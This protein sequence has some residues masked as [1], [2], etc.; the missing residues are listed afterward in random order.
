MFGGCSLKLQ[1]RCLAISG[2]QEGTLPF[3]Y[4]GVPIVSSRLTKMECRSLLDKMNTQ[5]QVWSSRN[6]SYAGRVILI[7]SVIFG[8]LNYWASIFI[9]PQEVLD[10]IIQLCNN[11]LWSG[12][13]EFK[14]TPHISW[15]TSC[16]PKSQVGL[17]IENISNSSFTV[18][19]P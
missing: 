8:M 18:H 9:L 6:I 19:M 10:S 3:K 15:D 4:L 17:G 7:N 5:I 14:R 2:F 11:F 16:L 13:A 1:Q 12:A